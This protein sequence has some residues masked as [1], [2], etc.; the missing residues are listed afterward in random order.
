MQTHTHTLFNFIITSVDNQHKKEIMFSAKSGWELHS[1]A[2]GIIFC[3]LQQV[4]LKWQ[5]E[6][7]SADTLLVQR[8]PSAA[9]CPQA[10]STSHDKIMRV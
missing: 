1:H 2:D 10:S 4:A 9:V 6:G 5:T 8:E 3:P 7:G